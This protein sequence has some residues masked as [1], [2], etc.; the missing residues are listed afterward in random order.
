[1]A[2]RVTA[3]MCA[4]GRTLAEPRLSPDGSLVAF[5]T[6]VSGRGQLVVASSTS[7]PEIVIT[8]QPAPRP[9][10]AYGGGAF[11]WLPDGS[12][13]VFAAAD[14]AL[15]L[16]PVDGGPPRC[17][18]DALP[19]GPASSPAVAPD[20]TKVACII[21]SHYVAVASLADDASWPSR[22]SGDVDFC[23]DPAFTSDSQWVAWQQWCVPDMPWDRSEIAARRA[24]GTGDIAIAFSEAEAQAQQVRFAPDGQ[25]AG[26]LTDVDGYLNLWT[27][28]RDFNAKPVVAEPFE[29]GDPSWGPGQR[30][31]A[32]SPDGSRIAF[33]RNEEGFGRLCVVDVGTGAIEDVATGVHGSLSW[34]GGRLAALRSGARTPTEIVVYDMQ[35]QRTRVARGPLAGFEAA[36]L[37]EPEVVEWTGDDGGVVHGRLYRPTTSATGDGPSPLICSIH[38]GPSSQ[39]AV[40]FNARWAF[41]L[42]RGWAVLVPDHRG[43]SGHG[44]AFLQAMRGRWGELD[45]SD[46]AAGLRAVAE[47][48]WADP[49]RMVV[50]GGSAGGFTVLNVLAHHPD[51]CA[52]GVDLYGVADLLELDE[53][54]HRFEKHYLHSIVGPLPDAVDKYRSHSPVSVVDEINA[55]LLILQGDADVVVPLAQSQSIADRLRALGR[56]VEL[57]VYEGEGHGWARPETVIDELERTEDFLRRHVLRWRS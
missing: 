26:F 56:T 6:T 15:W 43:S 5:V 46:V 18:L 7:G 2:P 25:L 8:S 14:G 37:G 36:D 10:A 52:A 23:F 21:D 30:S 57:H 50:M 42:D 34:R 20:G 54:T 13:L 55:P 12:G 24:D 38:G 31:Y 49:R 32:W 19:A 4:Y 17:V 51:L 35:W 11:D 9:S 40:L 48:G 44:R 45:T 53:T 22:L 27:F 47:R 33:N 1:M 29:H 3:A 39:S 41:W 28:D 16:A